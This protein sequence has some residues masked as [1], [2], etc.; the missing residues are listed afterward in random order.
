MGWPNSQLVSCPV[1]Q[2][3]LVGSCIYDRRN[4][5]RILNSIDLLMV[6]EV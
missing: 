4:Q 5:P 6:D 2:T 3:V 1:L